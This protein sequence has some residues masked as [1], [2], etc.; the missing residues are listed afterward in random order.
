MSSGNGP[1]PYKGEGKT[2]GGTARGEREQGTVSSI[3]RINDEKYKNRNWLWKQ[4]K[5][6]KRSSPQIA[7]DVGVDPTTIRKHL[8]K[9]DISIRPQS[10]AQKLSAH[11]SVRQWEDEE[12]LRKEYVA[13]GK[14]TPQIASEN[15]V[16]IATI[17]RAILDS[18]VEL[19]G[20]G[21]NDLCRTIPEL[22]DQ[23]W[24]QKQYEEYERTPQNIAD[25]LSVGRKRVVKAIEDSEIELRG[26]AE[27]NSIRWKHQQSVPKTSVPEPPDGHKTNPSSGETTT[28]NG[29]NNP[30]VSSE[31]GINDSWSS[32]L[33]DISQEEWVPYRSEDWLKW[34]Y[35]TLENTTYEMADFCET[36]DVTILNWMDHFG[37]ERDY[38]GR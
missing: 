23:D 4:Y 18:E 22:T 15:G 29:E 2:V 24:L 34:Q 20:P 5:A 6:L 26:R 3:G 1:S 12:W 30:R 13:K 37:I 10:E 11:G 8:R 33:Q 31:V 25:E 36:S 16:G 14:G 27:A 28:N 32:D 19:R 17:R 21:R 35:H 38:N 9:N 7:E